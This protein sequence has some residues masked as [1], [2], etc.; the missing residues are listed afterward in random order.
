MVDLRRP[1]PCCRATPAIISE[2]FCLVLLSLL[3]ETFCLFAGEP[4]VTDFP[5]SQRAANILQASLST[6]AGPQLSTAGSVSR[7]GTNC[8]SRISTNSMD[9]LDDKYRLAIGDRVSFRIEEDEEDSKMLTVADSGDLELPNIGRYPAVGRTC[10]ELA[11]ALKVELEKDYYY[12]ATV[13]IAV[14]LMTK[15]RGKVYLVGAVRIPG[16]EDIPS[17]EVFSLSKAVLRAGG[18]TDYADKRNVKVTRKGSTPGS[19][20]KTF[21]VNLGEILEKGKLNSD[22]TLQPGDLIYIPERF[23][24]F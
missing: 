15:S 1:I 7:G 5:E 17:D 9:V 4:M 8:A 6:N 19:A 21:T 24:H 20:D 14:D 18:F 23:I 13:I 10:K 3:F 16:P 11:Q 12:Q 2:P 22:P